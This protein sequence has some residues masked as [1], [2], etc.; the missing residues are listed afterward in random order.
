MPDQPPRLAE[1]LLRKIVGGRDAEIILGDLRE[2]FED[3]GGGSL[4]YWRQVASCLLIRLSPHHRLIPDL[5]RDL[6]YAFRIIRHNPGY[7]AAAMLCLA[8]GIGVNTTVFSWLDEMYFRRLDVPEPDRVVSIDRAGGPGCS[9]REYRDLALRLHSLSGLAALIPKGTYLDVNLVNDQIYAEVVSANYFD[10]LGVRPV[11]GR[12]FSPAGNLPSS[13]PVVVISDRAWR[14]HFRGDPRVLGKSLRIEGQWYRVIGVAPAS[15]RGASTPLAID[16]WVPL[17]TYPHYRPQ[18]AGAAS[19]N[20]PGVFLI[21]R[22]AK[23]QSLAQAAAELQVLDSHL[24]QAEPRNPRF[25]NPMAVRFVAGYSWVQVQRG[26]RPVS[27][28]LGCVVVVI[29]LIAC[30]NVANLLLSRAAVR[31]REM[32]VRKALGATR[33]QLVRQGLTEGLVLAIGGAFLGILLGSWASRAIAAF[34][35]SSHPDLALYTVHLEVNWRVAIFTAALSLF[36]ALAFSLAPAL[37]SARGDVTPLLKGGSE[38]GVSVHRLRQ[39]DW[40]VIVQVALSLVLLVSSALLIRALNEVANT[41]PGFAMDNRMYIRLFTQETDFTPAQA[42]SLYDRLLE[43]ARHLPGVREATLSFAVF[44]FM[45]GD[46]AAARQADPPRKLNINVVAPNYFEFMRVPLLHGRGFLSSD[47]PES[48][49]VIVVNETMAR[50]WWPN[51]DPIGKTAWLG[52]EPDR[53]VRAEVIGM[54]RDSKYGSL[55]ERPLPFYFVH[56]RQVWWNGFFALMLH[57]A[58]DPHALADPLL[59]LAR[60]GGADLRIYEIR[61]FDDLLALSLFRARWQATLLG[62]FSLLAIALAAIG[63]YGVVAYMTAQRTREIGIRMALGAQRADV[64]WLVLGRGLQL[65]AMGVLFGLLLSAGATQLLRRFLFGVS[66][67]DPL[68]FAAAALAWILISMLASY[69][70]ARR[71]AHIDPVVALRYE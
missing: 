36:C 56:W 5:T 47:R 22:L 63:L 53:R 1:F 41:D 38:G 66:P 6:H 17:A 37:D 33:S 10:V 3:R 39:R 34:L 9:W 32:A 60:T 30:V 69:L 14:R 48:P 25:K 26:L 12:A 50:R 29:L 67:L 19:S 28:V 11:L 7:A 44:G 59:Q 35:P 43:Q 58:G 4:W 8:L 46:C 18:L 71:A 65:A 20:G 45:D 27:T 40:L 52:C 68:A 54:V 24:R 57:T 64:K 15:F 49:R 62:A 42:T 51:E 16:A 21:G 70:P 31:R 13:D 61:S 55:D 23:A 2:L